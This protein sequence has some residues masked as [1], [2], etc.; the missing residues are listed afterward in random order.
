[1][2]NQPVKSEI[3]KFVQLSRNEKS[4]KQKNRYDAVL[5]YLEGR[6][7]REISEVLHIPR[8]TVSGYISL[9]T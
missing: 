3:E 6:S 5:L 4:V 2:E 9:Y 1:M 7:C 8:R